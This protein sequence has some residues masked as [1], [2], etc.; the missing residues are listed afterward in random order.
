VLILAPI[1]AII[2]ALSQRQPSG[3]LNMPPPPARGMHA[4]GGAPR[5]CVQRAGT[6]Y[7]GCGE[8]YARLQATMPSLLRRSGAAFTT[9]TCLRGLEDLIPQGA[10]GGRPRFLTGATARSGS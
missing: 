8:A 3:A 7:T 9:T 10:Q 4:E 6:T 5:S 2:L 1:L